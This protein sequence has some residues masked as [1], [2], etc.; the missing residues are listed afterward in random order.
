MKFSIEG[1]GVNSTATSDVAWPALVSGQPEATMQLYLSSILLGIHV[2]NSVMATFQVPVTSKGTTSKTHQSGTN[3]RHHPGTLA[4][5][6]HRYPRKKDLKV[7]KLKRR[8]GEEF[9]PFWMS[10]E[11]PDDFLDIQVKRNPEKSLQDEMKSLNL[12]ALERALDGKYGSDKGSGDG[13]VEGEDTVRGIMALLQTWMVQHAT[14]PVYYKW[15]DNGLLYWPR[16]V[17]SALCSLNSLSRSVAPDTL[18]PPPRAESCSWPPGMHCVPAEAKKLK[19]LRWTCRNSKTANRVNRFRL[20]E[21]S[22]DDNRLDGRGGG[23]ADFGRDRPLSDET[24]GDHAPQNNASSANA[25][26]RMIDLLKNANLTK[27]GPY[28]S[29]EINRIRALLQAQQGGQVGSADP[30]RSSSDRR[31][32]LD[33]SNDTESWNQVSRRQ[34]KR[35]QNTKC[36]WK[37]VPYPVTDDCYCSC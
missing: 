26:S 33:E 8:L 6:L 31:Q 22:D 9:D 18:A 10:I 32:T 7:D 25:T 11:L 12:T 28:S 19:L 5:D 4:D 30:P 2:V 27:S 16:W 34:R 35:Q 29:Q 23:D 37:K 15:V 1:G 21:T 13:P 24:V 17:R 3:E 36:N 14:C 20:T